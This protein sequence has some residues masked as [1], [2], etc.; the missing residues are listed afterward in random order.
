MTTIFTEFSD[1]LETVVLCK[2][3]LV[4]VSD[5]NIHVDVSDD[6]DSTKFLNLLESSSLQQH[7]A[8]PNHI[9]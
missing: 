1:Y 8:G 4:V 3:Q 7:V 5:F 2:E 9:H 6:S